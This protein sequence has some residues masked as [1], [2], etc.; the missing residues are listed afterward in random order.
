M[1]YIL[2]HSC[3]TN[4]AIK[5]GTAIIPRTLTKEKGHVSCHDPSCIYCAREHILYQRKSVVRHY[6]TKQLFA[7][8]D[9]P[10]AMVIDQIEIMNQPQRHLHY[11]SLDQI[12][13]DVKEIKER[14][15]IMAETLSFN[16][17]NPPP[18]PSRKYTVDRERGNDEQTKTIESLQTALEEAERRLQTQVMEQDKKIND[19]ARQIAEKEQR[20]ADYKRMIIQ[21]GRRE[22]APNDPQIITAFIKLKSDIVNFCMKRLTAGIRVRDRNELTSPDIGNLV[23]RTYVARELYNSF[24]KPTL[25]LFGLSSHIATTSSDTMRGRHGDNY[26]ATRKP[27]ILEEDSFQK[28]EKCF[29]AAARDGRITEGEVK[30]WRV[31]T[32]NLTRKAARTPR[33]YPIKQAEDIWKNELSQYSAHF[34]SGR[35]KG[36][37]TPDELIELC[38]SAYDIALLFR[39]SRIE[40]RWE[41]NASEASVLRRRDFEVLGTMGV[42]QSEPHSIKQVVFGEVIRGDRSTGKLEHGTTQLLKACVVLDFPERR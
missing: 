34:E 9:K 29:L 31:M 32:V 35:K 11:E 17:D 18:V 28:A 1:S 4:E 10:D 3:K 39:S 23:M 7:M 41:Q 12:S 26:N 15:S 27:A 38:Q 42:K 13:S 16:A 2:P 40:Y 8:A 21:S 14:V 36:S 33:E 30:E 25:N 37:E 20:L 6:P 5:I 19:Q 24:F 22:D